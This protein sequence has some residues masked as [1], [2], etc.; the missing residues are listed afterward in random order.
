MTAVG[1]ELVPG[2]CSVT[3]RALPAGEVLRLAAEH[4]LGAVEWGG[5]VHV[6]AG[7]LAAAERVAR[8]S[9]DAGVACASFGSYLQAGDLSPGAVAAT[10]DTTEALGAG[11]VRVW[12]RYGLGPDAGE[13]DRAAVADDLH[14]IAADAGHRRL[15]VSIE[16]HPGTL[17]ETADSTRR[18]LAA[19][20][21][22]NLFT[23]W[24]PAPGADPD[25]LRRELAGVIAD[26]SHLHVFAWT[27]DSTRRP[28]AEAESW[29]PAML[30]DARA[31]GRWPAD[32]VAFLE[33]VQDDE[34]AQLADDAACLRRWLRT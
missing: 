18:L 10:L 27:A 16:F 19:V 14:R 8:W 32:R 5:D 25:H 12:C 13:A 11:N 17:T 30:D 6:P 21:A 29:W 23:Y 15:T 26:L 20:G 33:F 9:A 34:V 31:S 28:L 4:G 7:D 22:D 2:L 24:Q 3:F 1:A